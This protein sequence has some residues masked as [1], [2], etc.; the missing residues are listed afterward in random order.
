MRSL[1]L[2]LGTTLSTGC[3]QP[4]PA[5]CPEVVKADECTKQWLRTLKPP[6]CA[7]NYFDR[8]GTQQ[9]SIEEECPRD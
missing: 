1:L 7:K 3:N 8:V 4:A 9:K 2:L 6:A 5:Y